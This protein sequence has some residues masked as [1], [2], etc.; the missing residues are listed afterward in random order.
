VPGFLC[1]PR[2]VSVVVQLQNF[3]GRR[4]GVQI[5]HERVSSRF[6]SVYWR[7]V[8]KQARVFDACQYK[9]TQR[10]ARNC[11]SKMSIK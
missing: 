5:S 6:N 3:G 10:L 4:Q 11:E 8:S 7:I 2:A 9:Q 1:I